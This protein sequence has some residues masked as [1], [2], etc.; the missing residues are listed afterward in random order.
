MFS[1]YPLSNWQLF[2]GE[3]SVRLISTPPHEEFPDEFFKLF[4]VTDVPRKNV[5]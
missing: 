2:F 3:L 1:K 5:H 4:S